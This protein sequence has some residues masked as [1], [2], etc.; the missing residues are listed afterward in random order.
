MDSGQARKVLGLNPGQDWQALMPAFLEARKGIA[1]L[2]TK[3]PT[4]L[5]EARYQCDLM[6]FDKALAFF[7]ELEEKQR[8]QERETLVVPLDAALDSASEFSNAGSVTENERP[9]RRGNRVAG[10]LLLLVLFVT[11]LFFSWSEWRRH[12]QNARQLM[13]ASWEAQA[14]D[15]LAKRRWED[16]LRIYEQIETIAPTSP[17]VVMGKRSIEIGMIEEQGQ[18]LGYWSGMAISAFEAGRWD[19]SDDAIAK[20]LEKRPGDVEMLQLSSKLRLLKSSSQREALLKKSQDA[21]NANQWDEAIKAADQLLGIDPNHEVAL[22]ARKMANDGK[23][24]QLVNATKAAGFFETAKNIDKGSFNSELLAII[25]EAKALDPNHLGIAALYEKVASY[26]R[27][28]RVP[29]E[30]ESLEL[31]LAQAKSEDRIVL[32]NG[33]Y[34]GPVIID[35]AIT[36]EAAGEHVVVSCPADRGPAMTFNAAAKGAKVSGVQFK[37]TSF[38]HDS[39]RF[40][41]VL[42]RGSSVE[43]SQCS[44]SRAA[45]HG[46]VIIAGGDV[47]AAKCRFIENGWDGLHATDDGTKVRLVDSVA[48]GNFQHGIDIWKQASAILEKNVSEENCLN[49]ILIDTSADVTIQNNQV[50]SN[51]EYGIFLREAGNSSVS[52][53]QISSNMQG[54]AV[55][56]APAKNLEFHD[57]VFEKNTGSSLRLGKG[58]LVSKFRDNFFKSSSVDEAIQADVSGE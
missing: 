13:L 20:V 17:I 41:A 55:L 18:F 37:H 10:M 14:A 42:V 9:V 38:N 4:E 25:R 6:E 28:L 29:M 39:E 45:G 15:H 16:A 26:S 12:Q 32:A 56:V 40:S 11:A 36:L 33:D 35:A 51:R 5:I 52:S 19:E 53:N 27:T 43:F 58:L 49:G 24:N 57:N 44:F 2:V 34:S 3:A 31:A 46:L 23:E 48:S 7:R 47:T 21:L 1:E 50:R 8:A 22:R 30:F 54:G